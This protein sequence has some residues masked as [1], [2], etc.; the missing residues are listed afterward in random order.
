MEEEAEIKIKEEDIPQGVKFII[1]G[2]IDSNTA[3]YFRIKLERAQK[4]K[5]FNIIMNMSEVEY[6]SSIGIRVIIKAYKVSKEAGGKVEIEKPSE[7]V[8]KVLTVTSLN[9]LLIQQ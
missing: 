8:R 9:E 2:R 1:T 5:K 6:L 3:D 7:I 4:N